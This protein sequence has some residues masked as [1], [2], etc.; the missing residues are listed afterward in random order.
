[1]KIRYGNT[2]KKCGE[3]FESATPNLD[4]CEK[5]TVIKE[6][7]KFDGKFFKDKKEDAE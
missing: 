7:K 3:W 6:A 2:C 4:V 1:M 5:C